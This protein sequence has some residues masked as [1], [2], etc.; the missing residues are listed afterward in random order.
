MT[1]RVRTLLTV[2]LTFLCLIAVLYT[3]SRI[4]LGGQ[5]ARI[6][7][8]LARDNLQRVI[9]D[10]AD[11]AEALAATAGDW[12]QWDETYAFVQDHNED[13][14]R[15]NLMSETFSTLRLNAMAF[16]DLAGGIVYA[17]GYDLRN[18]RPAPPPA[19]LLGRLAVGSRLLDHP[20]P[21]SSVQGILVVDGGALLVAS[22]PITS[23]SR[24]APVMGTLVIGRLI[25]AAEV[26]NIS[27]RM[28]LILAAHVPGDPAMDDLDRRAFAALAKR[29]EVI[30][31][32]LSEK[33]IA[34]YGLIPA[35]DGRSALLVKSVEPRTI[36]REGARGQLTFLLSLAVAG[37]V[38]GCVIAVFFSRAVLSPLTQLGR[39]MKRIGTA[40]I[41]SARVSRRRSDE[42]GTLADSINGML[43]AL[44]CSEDAQGLLRTQLAQAQKMEAIGTLAGGVAHDFNNIMT[45]I[46]G[47]SDYVLKKMEPAAPFYREIGQIKK[48]GERAAALTYQ[49]LAFSRKQ[50]LQP[51]T[52]DLNGVVSDTAAMLRQLIGEN[53]D[54]VTRLAASQSVVRI[55]PGQMQQV[56]MNLTVNSRDAMPQGGILTIETGNVT[57]DRPF[58]EGRPGLKPGEYVLLRVT[59][60]GVGMGEAEMAR[61]FEPFFTTKGLG[62]GTGLGLAVVFGIVK[63]SGGCIYASST[64]GSGSTFDIF[65][66]RVEAQAAEKVEAVP[67]DH[68]PA[69]NETILVAEDDQFVRGLVV[70]SLGQQGYRMLEAADGEQALRMA[71]G[72]AEK[73]HLL[74]TDVVMPVMGGAEL[75]K[76]LTELRPGLK[77][78]FMSGYSERMSAAA[79][80]PQDGAIMLEKP[81]DVGALARKV[82]TTLDG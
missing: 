50:M 58:A 36:F 71:A 68:R 47:Y 32:V 72:L 2:G 56:I 37:L 35:I 12:A 22:R 66:P 6:E 29:P 54:L 1:L 5:F 4:M 80:L 67:S 14:V 21:D 28:R 73:I 59:D 44:Q 74:L 46:I 61:I 75:A 7:G 55:D 79:A 19:G 41:T 18:Q 9:N 30:T 24:D 63:Q 15:S 3:T 23:S 76:R 77:V 62:K 52:I 82:R 10:L 43:D 57:V 17:E 20:G 26:S 65:L 13:Y 34:T 42:I 33:T 31:H 69:G 45:A 38:V 51:R 25:D 8:L 40:G 60:T 70:T 53:I 48:A 27:R 49:L 78:L 16:V 81:F 64:V 39:E 11:E